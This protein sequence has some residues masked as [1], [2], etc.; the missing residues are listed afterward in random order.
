[1]IMSE[2]EDHNIITILKILSNPREYN[3]VMHADM[4]ESEVYDMVEDLINSVE[5]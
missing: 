4:S 5:E 1:V 2:K 3:K